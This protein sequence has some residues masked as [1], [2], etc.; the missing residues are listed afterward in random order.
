MAMLIFFST[1]A[2]NTYFP[3]ISQPTLTSLRCAASPPTASAIAR[4][5]RVRM[6]GGVSNPGM[7]RSQEKC[8]D[9]K[10]TQ[11]DFKK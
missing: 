11:R 3:G 8:N 4:K 5:M 2:P 6:E 7:V 10:D 1:N 9:A